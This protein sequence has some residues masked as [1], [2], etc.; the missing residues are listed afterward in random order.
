LVVNFKIGEAAHLAS[1]TIAVQDSS[2]SE[3]PKGECIFLEEKGVLAWLV[4]A[5][6]IL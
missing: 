2:A 5:S 4:I 6:K 3:F 1:P